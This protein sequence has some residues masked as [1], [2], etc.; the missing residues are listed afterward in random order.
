MVS[1]ARLHET[2]KVYCRLRPRLPCDDE[3]EAADEA[4]GMLLT[5]VQHDDAE[6]CIQSWNADGKFVYRYQLRC[7][8]CPLCIVLCFTALFIAAAVAWSDLNHML[9]YVAPVLI[10]DG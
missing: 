10:A 4:T 8:L 1:D 6:C 9:R 7:A 5:E 3:D 2:V